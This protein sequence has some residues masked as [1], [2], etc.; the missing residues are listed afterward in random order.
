V[1]RY[2]IAAICLVCLVTAVA[3]PQR[4][5]IEQLDGYRQELRPLLDAIRQV[6]S[7]GDD[8]AIGDGGKAIGAYQIWSV[9][10]EDAQDWC[11]E[12]KGTW[13]DC[14]ARVYAER[15][16]AAYWHRYA[17][18]ALRNGDHETL[19][20]VHNGGPRGATKKATEGYW[21]KVQEALN[22]QTK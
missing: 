16:V 9:Y 10:H 21:R 17:R 19:A 1:I 3:Y 11:K 13:A 12:L 22:P 18:K 7:G 4:P 2:I 14:Y 6:E 8:S 5:T 15:C 20:R